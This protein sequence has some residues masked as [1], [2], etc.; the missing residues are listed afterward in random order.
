[1]KWAI[2]RVTLQHS[3]GCFFECWDFLMEHF[4]WT[5]KLGSIIPLL[6]FFLQKSNM[7]RKTSL[8]QQQDFILNLC[9]ILVKICQV[10]EEQV[11][12]PLCFQSLHLLSLCGFK[13]NYPFPLPNMH[14]LANGEPEPKPSAPL[15][16]Q[17]LWNCRHASCFSKNIFRFWYC[18]HLPVC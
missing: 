1:M 8:E 3:W 10:T 16:N 17:S 5:L 7:E 18:T 11:A 9:L 15:S 4:I 14:Q 12:L 13:M 2:I 6:V